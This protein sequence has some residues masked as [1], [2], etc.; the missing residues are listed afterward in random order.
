MQ[1][2]VVFVGKKILKKFANDKIIEKLG[3]IVISQLNMEAQRIV[4]VF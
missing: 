2:Y 3:T 1:K 4:F